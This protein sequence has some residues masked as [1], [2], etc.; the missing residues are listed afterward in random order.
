M[1]CSCT[2]TECMHHVQQ[3][4]G[5]TPWSVQAAQLHQSPEQRL[6]RAKHQSIKVNEGRGRAGIHVSPSHS[7]FANSTT[8]GLGYFKKKAVERRNISS[9][10]I[11]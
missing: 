6:G 3:L 10:V 9:L 11:V 4:K 5:Q 2:R 8:E 1:Q 7:F